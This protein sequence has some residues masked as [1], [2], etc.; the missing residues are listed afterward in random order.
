MEKCDFLEEEFKL[1]I[2]KIQDIST[3]CNYQF[4]R[5]NF[6]WKELVTCFND[7]KKIESPIRTNVS[8]VKSTRNN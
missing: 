6:I 8:N 2:R 5:C 1:C 7:I 3:D 4:T